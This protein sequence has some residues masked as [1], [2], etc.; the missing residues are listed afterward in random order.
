MIALLLVLLAPDPEPPSLVK[1][2]ARGP[3]THPKWGV[4]IKGK[5]LIVRDAGELVGAT[6][7]ILRIGGLDH[8]REDATNEL[9]R[10]LKAKEIDWKKHMV[11]A[12]CAGRKPSAGYRVEITRVAKEKGVLKVSWQLIVPKG[13]ADDVLTYPS[14][15]VLL[16]RFA[17]KVVFDPP[18]ARK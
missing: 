14:E 12:V 13:G 8:T 1:A 15:C 11:V 4:P 18:F 10:S 3:W 9:L 7:H 17:G 5:G 6:S 2:L 16:P